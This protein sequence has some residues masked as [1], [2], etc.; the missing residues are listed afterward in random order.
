MP[1]YIRDPETKEKLP[2]A[3][4]LDAQIR[5]L[6]SGVSKEVCTSADNFYVVFPQNTPATT[7][8]ALIG[9]T[10]LLD[11]TIFEEKS[12]GCFLVQW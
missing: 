2:G 7:K 10:I 9:S 8:G 12:G 5:K 11:F 6:W 4:G 1:F 3:K